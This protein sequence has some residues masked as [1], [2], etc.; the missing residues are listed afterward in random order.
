[1]IEM[2]RHGLNTACCGSSAMDFFEN[3][4][5]M[6][7]DERLQEAEETGADILIDICQTCHNIF[8]KEELKH[9]FEI[10]NYGSLLSEAL[11]IEREDKYKKY[12]QWGSLER[13][14]TDAQE[15]ITQSQ[16]SYDY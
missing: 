1:M 8:A 3:S 13:I 9:S 15:F 6:I 12:K 4:M 16:Y 7:R 14:L 11:G 10:T 5:E 2:P